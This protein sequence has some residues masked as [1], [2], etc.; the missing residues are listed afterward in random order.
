MYVSKN[1]TAGGFAAETDVTYASS[2]LFL[3][4]NPSLVFAELNGICDFARSAAWKFD[5]APHDIGT[6][7]IADGQTYGLKADFDGDKAKVYSNSDN[8]YDEEK[9]AAMYLYSLMPRR[10]FPATGALLPK[11]K[12]CF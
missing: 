5:F 4:Y 11:I 3:L 10:F 8:I 2:P 12:I 6:Y 9:Q 1:C 7:P